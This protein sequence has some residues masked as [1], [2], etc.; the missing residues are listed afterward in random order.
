MTSDRGMPACMC[1]HAVI[2]IKKYCKKKDEIISRQ[3]EIFTE[4]ELKYYGEV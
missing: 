2:Y 1:S 3:F 4:E